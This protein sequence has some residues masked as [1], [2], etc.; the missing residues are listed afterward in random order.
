MA[1]EIHSNND[2]LVE[3]YFCQLPEL[4][5]RVGPACPSGVT[6]AV[7]H[8]FGGAAAYADKRIFMSL[9]KAGLALK[10]PPED[11]LRLFRSGDGRKL[12]YFPNAPVKKQ[13][14]LVSNDIVNDSSK[15]K[16]L[17]EKSIVFALSGDK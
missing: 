1:S 3:D 15:I 5:D 7:R 4:L 14:A 10:L 2:G 6:I 8:F 17:I 9:T 11:R 12:R 16:S 13:Y